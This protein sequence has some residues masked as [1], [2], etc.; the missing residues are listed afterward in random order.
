MVNEE[1]LHGGMSMA[2]MKSYDEAA[3]M[4]YC[5]QLSGRMKEAR[6]RARE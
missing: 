6:T 5:R 1:V 3:R 4:V 2:V